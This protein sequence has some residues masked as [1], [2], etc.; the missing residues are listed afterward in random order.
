MR[1]LN[2]NACRITRDNKRCCLHTLLISDRLGLSKDSLG[3][4]MCGFIITH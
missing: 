2:K 1:Q 4:I 3:I